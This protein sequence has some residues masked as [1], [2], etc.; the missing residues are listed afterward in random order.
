MSKQQPEKDGEFDEER[1][2]LELVGGGGGGLVRAGLP[3]TAAIKD[4]TPSAAA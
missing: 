2:T 4:S 1:G 3:E